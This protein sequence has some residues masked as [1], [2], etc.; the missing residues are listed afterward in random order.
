MSNPNV[1]VI[2]YTRVKD[3]YSHILSNHYQ[4]SS[5]SE[6]HA[7]ITRIADFLKCYEVK[8]EQYTSGK[9]CS[10]MYQWFVDNGYISD[11]SWSATNNTIRR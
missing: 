4:F 6:K 9:M 3:L 2:E 8:S 11:Q 10:L 5:K 7:V 1:T